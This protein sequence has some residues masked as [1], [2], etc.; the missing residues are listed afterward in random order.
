M[1]VYLY[2][3]RAYTTG[4]RAGFGLSSGSCLVVLNGDVV[5]IHIVPRLVDSLQPQCLAVEAIEWKMRRDVPF[6]AKVLGTC[7]CPATLTV[8]IRFPTSCGCS[9]PSIA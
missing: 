6:H 3:R 5:A 1:A 9:V 2:E 8:T 7:V 4:F